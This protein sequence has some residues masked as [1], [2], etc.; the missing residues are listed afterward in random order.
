MFEKNLSNKNFFISIHPF[1]NIH[2]SKSNI[3][4]NFL[5]LLEN[6]KKIGNK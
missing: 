1:E 6:N 3:T 5:S 4:V 2:L